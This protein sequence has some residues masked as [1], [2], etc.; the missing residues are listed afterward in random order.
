MSEIACRRI[1]EVNADNRSQVVR[2]HPF[3]WVWHRLNQER[4][5]VWKSFMNGLT[6]VDHSLAFAF[7]LRL[8][9]KEADKMTKPEYD[10]AERLINSLGNCI[11]L[12]AEYNC[13]KSD[14]PFR[15]FF[16]WFPPENEP[17][18]LLQSCMT[19]PQSIQGDNVI[20]AIKTAIRT[21]AQRIR[22][23]LKSFARGDEGYSLHN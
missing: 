16:S 17:K 13:S 9:G 11:L 10:E 1:D 7:W 2:Y 23:E 14:E 21:R 5:N 8:I 6:H 4:L 12:K 20:R 18:L 15:V 3:L 19:A 22:E